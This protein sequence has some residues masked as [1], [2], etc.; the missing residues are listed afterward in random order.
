MGATDGRIVASELL[1]LLFRLVAFA[2]V[3]TEE[4]V[5]KARL[6]PKSQAF[7]HLDGFVNSRVV[8]NA[9]EPKHLVEAKLQ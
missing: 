4:G 2:Q 6:R 5:D 9:V 1:K 8:G 7:R 3:A